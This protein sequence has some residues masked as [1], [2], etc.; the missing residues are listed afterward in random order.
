MCVCVCVCVL[1]GGGRGGASFNIIYMPYRGRGTWCTSLLPTIRLI[2]L[3]AVGSANCAIRTLYRGDVV[4]SE[5]LFTHERGR[6]VGDDVAEVAGVD[7]GGRWAGRGGVAVSTVLPCVQHTAS[8]RQHG[9]ALYSA[10]SITTSARYCPV[11]SIQHHHVS[12]VLIWCF[13]RVRQPPLPYL[14]QMHVQLYPSKATTSHTY[15]IVFTS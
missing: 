15:C 5:A 2:R 14:H 4:A 11:F 3:S 10:Y 7:L 13:I 6:G 8:P 12:T 9:I 1:G